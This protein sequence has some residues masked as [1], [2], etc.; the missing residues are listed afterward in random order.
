MEVI[1]A[2]APAMVAAGIV[3]AAVL[4]VIAYFQKERTG[5]LAQAS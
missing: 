2:H 3:G 4:T 1:A 5:Y